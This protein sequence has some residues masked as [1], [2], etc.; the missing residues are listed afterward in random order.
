[1]GTLQLRCGLPRAIGRTAATDR[2]PG[3]K[4]SLDA[5]SLFRKSLR[6]FVQHG[7]N[8]RMS[9]SRTTES[10]CISEACVRVGLR[11][12]KEDQSD[13]SQKV[14]SG[15]SPRSSIL[16]CSDCSC[17]TAQLRYSTGGNGFAR[18]QYSCLRGTL[19]GRCE[20]K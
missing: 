13:G 4:G 15:N 2:V 11:K 16:P 1:M 5:G 7:P 6:C 19:A 9:T 14:D 10:A 8:A 20:N 17:T 18:N 3:I 12:E